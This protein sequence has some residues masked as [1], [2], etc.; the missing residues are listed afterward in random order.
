[1]RQD[2][3][4]EQVFEVVNRILH[5][6]L[7]TKKRNLRVR[8][9]KVIPL[10]PR[11]GL[12]EFVSNTMPMQAW[13]WEAHAKYRPGDLKHA[14]VDSAL[15]QKHRDE[16][17]TPD[18]ML[19][20]FQDLRA[21]FQPVFRHY[22]TE[23]RKTP[24]AWFAMRLAYTRSVATTSIVGH[25]IGL[26]DRHCSNIL[27]D[28]AS[29]EVV[30]I[31][32]GIAFD[33]GKKL[34]VPERVPFRMTADMIDGMGISG[35]QGV[36][37]RCAEETLRVLRDGSSTINTVLGVFR[38]DPLHTW[39]VSGERIGRVQGK[40]AAAAAAVAAA[41]AA[42]EAA[43]V[44]MKATIGID[45]RSTA[46][47]QAADRALSAVEKKLEKSL[48][49]EYTVNELLAEAT[50]P[51]HLATMFPGESVLSK[52]RMVTLIR[53]N[54]VGSSILIIGGHDPPV[55]YV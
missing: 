16:T 12:L 3:V 42:D 19:K 13:L 38:H 18:A 2:A 48:S 33:Q 41:A 8:D 30:H 17:R 25:I 36:F 24:S 5:R 50:D 35:T 27:L 1:M 43:G 20:L 15:R 28:N 44:G 37:Q 29:G 4:M 49:V 10:A 39:T 11:A 46:A 53:A 47:D 23:R 21:R 52:W 55:I 54:R 45:G 34:P 22:F 40:D 31:D 14:E 6:D 32:L 51:L 9:Y 7:E 26:G